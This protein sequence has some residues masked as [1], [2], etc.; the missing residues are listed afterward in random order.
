MDLRLLL[1]PA[2]DVPPPRAETKSRT[3]F[4]FLAL[5]PGVRNMVYELVLV[6]DKP[7]SIEPRDTTCYWMIPSPYLGRKGTFFA[8]LL[9]AN[10]QINFEGGVIFFSRNTFIVGC[11]HWRDPQQA[12]LHGLMAFI[13]RVPKK[14]ISLIQRVELDIL[15]HPTPTPSPWWFYEY[16]LPNPAARD[17]QTISKQLLKHF[18]GVKDILVAAV[19]HQ[20]YENLENWDRI[21]A[22]RSKFGQ[23]I[24]DVISGALQMLLALPCLEK[25]RFNADSTPGG[26]LG[27]PAIA[28]WMTAVLE[29]DVKSTGK[30]EL[31]KAAR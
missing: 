25:L 14:F 10:K 9:R 23:Y 8:C 20:R 6:N 29:R 7:V 26:P 31:W 16:N 4:K 5:P 21:L 30:V 27:V 22:N 19:D 3:T 13:A 11:G 17:V 24:I 15:C 12:N 18:T 2:P 28:T 1:N